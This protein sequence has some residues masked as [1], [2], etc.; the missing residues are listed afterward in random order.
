MRHSPEYFATI[1]IDMDMSNQCTKSLAKVAE[2]G[3]C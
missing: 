1:H 2:M 3:N